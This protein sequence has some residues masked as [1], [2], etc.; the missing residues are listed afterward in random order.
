MLLLAGWSIKFRVFFF[1]VSKRYY[2]GV[3]TVLR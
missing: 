1:P 2:C 3:V